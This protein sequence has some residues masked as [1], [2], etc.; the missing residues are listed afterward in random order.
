[1]LEFKQLF[2]IFKA[3]CSVDTGI[4]INDTKAFFQITLEF[5]Q[6]NG[7]FNKWK[8]GIFLEWNWAFSWLT[9]SHFL[10]WHFGIFLNDTLAFPPMIL[11]H[12]YKCHVFIFPN[13]TLEFSWMTLCHFREWHFS[14]FMNPTLSAKWLL[15]AR[16]RSAKW[17]LTKRHGTDLTPF[18]K[19]MKSNLQYQNLLK[20]LSGKIFNY[21]Q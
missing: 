14:I 4:L 20:L 11:W 9:W 17:F 15:S 8:F 5:Y 13:D 2:R 7:I 1:M 12:F 10:K 19:C 21:V 6:M 18:R 3:R 16:C